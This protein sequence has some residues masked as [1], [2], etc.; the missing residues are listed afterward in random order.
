M[1]FQLLALIFFGISITLAM[2]YDQVISGYGELS[3]QV[4]TGVAKEA[5]QATGEQKHILYIENGKENSR[6]DSIYRLNASHSEGNES[7]KNK[8]I[9]KHG[10]FTPNTY[11][12]SLN[13]E[14]AIGHYA[15]IHSIGDISSTSTVKYSP[16]GASTDFNISAQRGTIEEKVVSFL[17]KRYLLPTH[18]RD[19]VR[20][21]ING[22][23]GIKSHLVDDAR[24]EVDIQDRERLLSSLE[25]VDLYGEIARQEIPINKN[26]TSIG[27]NTL[28]YPDYYGLSSSSKKL[29]RNLSSEKEKTPEVLRESMDA[30]GITDTIDISE[31]SI[32]EVNGED[33]LERN[34][35]ELNTMSIGDPQHNES[36][37]STNS[38]IKCDNETN[39]TTKA[40]DDWFNDEESSTGADPGI[41]LQLFKGDSKE[42]VTYEDEELGF[43][44]Y[45]ILRKDINKKYGLVAEQ[46]RSRFRL[47]GP[48]QR[49]GIAHVGRNVR[50][51]WYFS[52]ETLPL[53]NT[54]RT[55]A[56][57][58]QSTVRAD[59]GR[60]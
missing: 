16:I 34:K 9:K 41:S 15:E 2:Q 60:L 31:S 18:G 36:F 22:S 12:I 49:L 3:S 44:T 59:G 10:Y 19:L 58:T 57:T 53:N 54:T 26:A 25:S 13:R 38:T 50:K 37:C 40:N 21:S 4:N 32:R 28:V 48:Q 43:I 33:N 52:N 55:Q 51:D 47:G 29:L 8:K 46:E 56:I 5:V 30:L 45:D 11:M 1:K 23:M 20:T 24:L 35:K 27:G 14:E 7:G 42:P 17:D 39:K 6:L